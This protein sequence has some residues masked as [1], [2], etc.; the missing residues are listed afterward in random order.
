MHNWISTLV[1]ERACI[2]EDQGEDGCVGA[3]GPPSIVLDFREG[4]FL[5]SSA[6][7]M[8]NQAVSQ[9]LRPFHPGKLPVGHRVFSTRIDGR[10]MSAPHRARVSARPASKGRLGFDPAT[11]SRH[12][13]LPV[14]GFFDAAVQAASL[15]SREH[16]LNE[17]R[18]V[19]LLVYPRR[20]FAIWR[21]Y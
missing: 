7:V 16:K 5:S 10:T 15:L 17:R 8:S 14:F 12:L 1:G 3:C 11:R 13:V 9:P 2:W 19:M 18:C 21:K 20:R 4:S 6:A